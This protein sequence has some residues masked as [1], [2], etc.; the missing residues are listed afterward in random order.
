MQ[1]KVI[2]CPTDFNHPSG[3]ALTYAAALAHDHHARLIVLH[4]VETLGPENVTYG[5]AVSQ[6]QPAAYRQR[7]WDD[8]HQVKSPDDQVPVEYAM[9]EG[10]P[11]S[12]IVRF[13]AERGC[14]L[15]VMGTRGSSGIRRW[16]EGS[17]TEQVVRGSPC[18]VLVVK[19]PHPP[20]Q[21]PPRTRTELHPY[22]LS[23][24]E[25]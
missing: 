12:A 3:A 18:P 25:K 13:A 7:L 9:M 23:E 21:S 22:R 17:V 1:L 10:E 16:L 20:G 6:R 11:A 15:I 5:E 14:D 4:V 2:L 24:T 8:L 19:S